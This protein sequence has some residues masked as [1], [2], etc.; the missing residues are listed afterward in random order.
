MLTLIFMVLYIFVLCQKTNIKDR[1]WKSAMYDELESNARMQGM[2]NSRPE[3]ATVVNTVKP[4]TMLLLNA[5][6]I[7]Y[8]AVWCISLHYI[9]LRYITL[10]HISHQL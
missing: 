5:S 7:N 2:L 8:T 6:S 10:H 4:S 9:A 3:F 1:A